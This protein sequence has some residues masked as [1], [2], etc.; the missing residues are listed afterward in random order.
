MAALVC[1][2]PNNDGPNKPVC[3]PAV[4]V[5]YPVGEILLT[6]RNMQSIIRLYGGSSYAI[7]FR[8]RIPVRQRSIG[9]QI[10]MAG[11]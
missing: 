7:D 10:F 11:A 2:R 8:Q 6:T 5:K 1:Q 3:F 9:W 4:V